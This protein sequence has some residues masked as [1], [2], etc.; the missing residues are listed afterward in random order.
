M[1]ATKCRHVQRG[2][3]GAL[4]VPP[5]P[6]TFPAWCLVLGLDLTNVWFHR[7]SAQT[8]AD[9]ACTAGAMD[10]PVR[11]QVG[12]TGHQGFTTGT[13]FDCSSS[14][15]AAYPVGQYANFNGYN[16]NNATPGNLVNVSFP[17]TPLGVTA[18]PAGLAPTA[19]IRV[20]VLDRT[21]T[22]FRG[23]AQWEHNA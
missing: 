13:A 18:P 22:F 21:Q 16:S 11:A 9:A 12:A 17:G 4:V 14:S 23:L 7:Q 20:D 15:T 19:F 1:E 8:A 5:Y 2:R 3:P 10:L 6:G